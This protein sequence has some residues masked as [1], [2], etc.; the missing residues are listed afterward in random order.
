MILNSK[1]NKKILSALPPNIDIY[2]VGGAVRDHFLRRTTYDYD[3]VVSRDALEIGK[4][5]ADQLR[6][7]FFPLDE[8]RDTARVIH[9]LPDGTQQVLDF[10][11]FRGSDIEKDLLA[12]DFTI[13]AIAVDLQADEKLL[14]P[15]SGMNDLRS[16]MIRACS[17]DSF[18]DDPLRVLRAIRQASAFGFRIHPE[19]IN[20]MRQEVSRLSGISAERIRDELFRILMLDRSAT[21]I[22]IM[23]TM[24]ILEF[25]LPELLSLKGVQ[26]SPPHH[27]DVWTHTL[28]VVNQLERLINVL[29]EKHDPEASANWVYG[30]ASVQL[31]RYRKQIAEH[32]GKSL[33]ADRLTKA[34]VLLA[35]LYHDIGKPMALSN[36]EDGRIRFFEHEIIGSEIVARRGRN[37][38]L[39]NNEI[40]YLKTVVRHHMRPLLLVNSGIPP[41]RRSIYRFFRDT[42]AIGIDI[43]VLSLADT[44]ATYG[45]AVPKG[46]WTDHLAVTRSLLAAWWEQPE[47]EVTPVAIISGG[48]LIEKF[49]IK[50]GPLVGELLEMIR[51]GQATGQIENMEQALNFAAE[52]L[53]SH[54]VETSRE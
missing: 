38:Q 18:V 50:P 13:N 30:F 28:S 48:D 49:G 44:L 36:D 23:D 10:A 20:L 5:V 26:Q 27:D 19:T 47:K 1:L 15:L 52:W 51:E 6:G 14:D 40:G 9:Y 43:C 2:L 17:A 12:R 29:A 3:F 53:D 16:G 11:S 35:G 25:V 45:P 21:S 4:K 32:M 42:G 41:S 33:T 31:G 24:G 8:A 37:L 34:L 39:S 46:L 7:A 54:S 22:R